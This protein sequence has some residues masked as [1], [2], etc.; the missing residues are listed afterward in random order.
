MA[1]S[2][3]KIWVVGLA[4]FFF[5]SSGA[6]CGS[7]RTRSVAFVDADE[8]GVAMHPEQATGSLAGRRQS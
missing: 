5:V 2:L 3:Q 4:D 6:C 1:H 8:G 7:C